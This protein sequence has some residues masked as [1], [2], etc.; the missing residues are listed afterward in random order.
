MAVFIDVKSRFDDASG[1]R[2]AEEA[3]GF[4]GRA[5]TDAG[6][7]FTS[8]FARAVERDDKVRAA[9]DKVAN[10]TEKIA[11][12]EAKRAAQLERQKAI[13][14][15]AAAEE[16]KLTAARD[17]NNADEVAASEERLAAL[18]Q[19]QVDADAR[20]ITQAAA[21][22]RAERDRARAVREAGDA[23][24]KM[25]ADLD[26]VKGKFAE[27]SAQFGTGLKLN[28]GLAG[29][30]LLP[31]AATAIADVA[32]ALQQLSGAGFAVPG[33]FAG[34][35]SS[36]GV[37]ALG[38]YGMSDAITAVAK[39]SDG[40]KASVEA[41]NEA[42]ANLAPAQA[43]VV[44]TAVGL[45]GTFNE[46]RTLGSGNMFAGVSDGIRGLVA[47]DLPAVTRG[48]DG[49][50][51]GI[52]QN[53]LQAMSSLG[54]QS[55]QGFL[56]RIFGNTADA[57]SKLT[58][59]IDPIVHAVGTLSAA[60]SDTLPRLATAVGNVADRFDRFITA[61]DGDG[62]LDKWID[63][64]ITG[65]TQLGNTALNIGK[66][67]TAI[68]QAAGGGA[69]LLGTLE[70]GTEKLQ[71]FLNSTEGQSKLREYFAEGRDML[72]QLKDVA[73]T[74]GPV[75]AGVFSAGVNAANMWLP[76]I[77]DGLDVL[78]RIPG[79]AEAVVTA[80][81]AWKLMQGPVSLINSLVNI[82]TQLGGLPTK[83][84]GAARG[85]NAA[86]AT[87]VVP[88][89]G[90]MLNDQI[91][92]A[93]RQNNPD[94]YR[95]NNANTPDELGKR[96]RDWVDRNVFKE[97]PPAQNGVLPAAPGSS[98]NATVGGIPIPG[99]VNQNPTNP[100]PP[101]PSAAPSVSRGAIDRQHED[102]SSIPLYPGGPTTPQIGVSS[103]TDPVITEPASGSGADATPYI[104]PSKYMAGDPL[105]GLPAPLAGVDQGALFDSDSKLLTATHNLEQKR[106][107]IQVL[108]AKGN[109]TQQEL[110]TARNDLQEAERAQ[111][112]AQQD[113]IKTRTGQMKQTTSDMQSI[114]APLDQDFGISKGIPGIVENL[115]KTFGNLALGSA[116]GSSPQLQAAA[117]PLMSS[118]SGAAGSSAGSTSALVGSYGSS[119]GQGAPGAAMPGEDPRSFAHRVMMPFW[120]SKGLEV[121]DHAADQ[122]GEHQNGALDIM[123]GS[124]AEG[125]AVLQQV[126]SDPN[127]KGA[128]FNNQTYGYGHGM[129]PRDYSA[130][131]TGDPN[132]DHTNHVHALY[133][134]GDP[135]NINPGGAPVAGLGATSASLVGSSSGAT[136]V[137]VVN[138]PGGDAGLLGPVTGAVASAA[139]G[140]ASGAVA[141][142][143]WDALA[144]KESSGNWKINTGNGYFGG[145]QFDQSTWDASGG[146]AY[147]PRADLA[148]RE[149]QIAVASNA[150]A[151]RG[152]DPSSL[153][154]QN[155]GQLYSPAAGGAGGPGWFPAG[156][157]LPSIP[158]GAGGQGYG[159]GG[160]PPL[161]PNIG[162]APLQPGAPGIGGAAGLPGM[163]GAGAT[164][165]VG[166]AAG[167]P[168]GGVAPQGS[169]G[170]GGI[171]ITP[172]GT[173]DSA[174]TAA[175]SM[176]PGGGAAAGIGIKLASRAIQYAGQAAGIGASGLMETFLP[177]GSALGNFGNSWFGKIAGGIA[178]ARP[179]K[180]NTIPQQGPP[181]MSQGQQGQGQGQPQNGQPITLNYTNNQATE[182][183]AGQDLTRHLTSAM[184]GPGRG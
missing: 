123:V 76:V 118:G 51:R 102:V 131:H 125:N 45:R 20:L 164:G 90:Q 146:G 74:A 66:T 147:A 129:T 78:N 92:E 28:L 40:T 160:T 162:P 168:I 39:A 37:G 132:Q 144:A 91:Q 116:I 46:L 57:Q 48:V 35:A 2:A 44:K 75:L 26:D 109:A 15:A 93:L 106:L 126:L 22:S 56:D 183:R 170:G 174:I 17:A 19:K 54:S 101:G 184:S 165:G 47:A 175:A 43:D 145:L 104:D 4:F 24:R 53:L 167:Q 138:M 158:A 82:G 42:L 13:T 156:A 107:A 121:G 34:I 177:S 65:F 86:L 119:F 64:G 130:G 62:R 77:R 52:N 12:A 181:D 117:A 84:Q 60:G 128:I 140:A 71:L 80:F 178:G 173:I 113:A 72:G 120:Q 137:F 10:Q 5:G 154:P 112:D 148:S 59:A 143:N 18:R 33:I 103:Y 153:W 135:G 87:I 79:G 136:P 152:G 36:V 179:A 55:S 25:G 83:A 134:P 111:Y 31:A 81:D 11:A 41:A 115:V 21:V 7:D 163:L 150:L 157:A 99:L 108:E 110:L 88:A 38:M 1:R 29:I 182:D 161:S 67:F 127:V 3:K 169:T 172:G 23:Y 14:A 32:G 70:S 49:I 124:I 139:N 105:A 50:S 27:A 9:A 166:A 94:A 30:G 122:Y 141:N 100:A 114:F 6:N 149:Q 68:T 69:G 142:L 151:A 16:Q 171:G 159:I 85:I 73:T 176:F 180:P 95:A 98:P 155:Y 61:A 96:A 58:A 89:I 133:K 63:E 97:T 8:N